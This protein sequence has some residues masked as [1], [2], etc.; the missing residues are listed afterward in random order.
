MSGSLGELDL[1]LDGTLEDIGD[2]AKTL[3][4]GEGLAIGKMAVVSMAEAAAAP[5]ALWLADAVLAHRLRWLTP[6]PLSAGYKQDVGFA[7]R[8]SEGSIDRGE[9]RYEWIRH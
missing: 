4:T 2:A 3:A 6:V 1:L 5:L 9:Q 7:D 8:P